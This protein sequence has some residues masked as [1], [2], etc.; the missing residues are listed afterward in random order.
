MIDVGA[1]CQEESKTCIFFQS[2]LTPCRIR[3]GLPWWLRWW[4][5]C[6]QWRRPGFDSWVGKVPWRREWQPTTVFLPGKF[7]GQRKAVGYRPWGHKESD[8]TKQLT[9]STIEGRNQEKNDT[10]WGRKHRTWPLMT[11]TS[12]CSFSWVWTGPSNS[13]LIQQM[14]R[15]GLVSWACDMST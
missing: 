2:A 14:W 7:H 12:W 3:L 13:L 9:L 10:G 6:L 5:I 15:A 8:M 11:P 1:Q 4:R